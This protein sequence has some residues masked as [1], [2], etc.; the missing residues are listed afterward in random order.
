MNLLESRRDDIWVENKKIRF[1]CRSAVGKPLAANGRYR[2]VILD[3]RLIFALK[4]KRV[5]FE[6]IGFYKYQLVPA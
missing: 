4:E 3:F 2:I 1:Q 5:R 6:G